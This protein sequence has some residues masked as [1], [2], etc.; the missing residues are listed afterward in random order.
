[1]A[2]ESQAKRSKRA[3]VVGGVPE[4]FNYPWHLANE[5]GLFQKHGV[6]VEFREQKLGTGA[7]VEAAKNGELDLIIALTEGL[8]AEMAT[9]SDLRLLG[10][11]V[12]SPLC[13]AISTGVTS[14]INDVE[15]LRNGKFGISRMGSGSQL[16]AYVLA[17]QRGWNTDEIS[18]EVKGDINCLC[19]GVNDQSTDAFLWETFTTKPYHDKGVVRRIGDITTPWPCFMLAA[20]SSIIDERLSEIQ[21]CLSA[22]HEAALLFHED[23]MMPTQI[24]EKYGL[25]LADATKWY[26]NVDIAASRFVSEAALEKAVEALK[27]CKR[28]PSTSYDVSTFID[29]RVAELYR[30]V[31]SMKLYDQS[32]LVIAIHRQLAAKGMSKGALNFKDLLPFDQHHYYGTAAVDDVIQKC[33]LSEVSRVINI[34]AGL[35]GPCRYISGTVACQTLACEVQDDLNRT[36]AELTERC[37]LTSKVHHMSG[38]FMVLAQHLQ[39]GG[40]DAIVSWLTVLHF[41]DR[42]QLFKQCYEL[43]RPGGFF[44]AADF[45]ARNPLSHEEKM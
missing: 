6:E 42:L 43:L 22:V 13:W 24:A 32:E 25:Q 7:M 44:F 2:S 23:K 5:K 33:R 39:R 41:S 27:V 40:Y 18:F 29:I 16:M 26:N 38:D 21:S 17:I 4:H 10:T 35:G 11:Y 15:D 37:N 19:D 31:L 30:D 9:G 8:V 36:A 34:G 45:F 20:K 3:L 14:S 28:I 1:M 12:K